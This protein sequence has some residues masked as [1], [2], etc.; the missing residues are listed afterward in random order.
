MMLL[1]GDCIG[2]RLNDE[3][4]NF[5]GRSPNVPHFLFLL[6]SYQYTCLEY[7]IKVTV[8]IPFWENGVYSFPMAAIVGMR[9]KKG[10]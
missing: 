1:V 8:S 5:I 9:K 2:E 7:L 10:V 6:V 3:D 4:L